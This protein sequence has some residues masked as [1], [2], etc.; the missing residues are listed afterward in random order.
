M[1]SHLVLIE[2][3]FIDLDGTTT[4]KRRKLPKKSRHNFNVFVDKQFFIQSVIDK[5]KRR[6]WVACCR[7]ATCR[8][9]LIRRIWND[10]SSAPSFCFFVP[11]DATCSNLRRKKW[12]N[13]WKLDISKMGGRGRSTRPPGGGGHWF[14]LYWGVCFSGFG[15]FFY[16]NLTLPNK[17][18]T[19]LK[20][21]FRD[22]LSIR[23]Q[24]NDCHYDSKSLSIYI[25]RVPYF[26]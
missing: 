15:G 21:A 25:D 22:W 24:N 1:L 4:C 19:G 8:Y 12:K 9:V 5:T 18:L 10:L 23:F 3:I 2:F 13:I 11:N 6:G 20:N 7:Y 14:D 16:H 17:K 26:H